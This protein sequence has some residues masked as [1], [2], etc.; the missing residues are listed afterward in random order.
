MVHTPTP[1]VQEGPHKDFQKMKLGEVFRPF[2][3]R[4]LPKGELWQKWEHSFSKLLQ[5][6]W[7]HRKPSSDLSS[8]SWTWSQTCSISKHKVP[9]SHDQFGN[10]QINFGV[11]QFS[12]SLPSRQSSSWSHLKKNRA[13]P[14]NFLVNLITF[15]LF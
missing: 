12:S 15:C 11:G 10:S 3:K 8:Q 7:E 13:L 5:R 4:S 6:F 2:L 14:L 9:L 1:R